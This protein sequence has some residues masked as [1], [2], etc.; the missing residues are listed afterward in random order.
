MKERPILFGPEMVRAILDGSKTMTRRIV[1][2]QP[3]AEAC[4]IT[5]HPSDYSVEV[6]Q[7]KI[8][9]FVEIA[10]DLWPCNRSEAIACPYGVPGDRLWVRETFCNFCNGDVC[11]RAT[12]GNKCGLTNNEHAP[13]KWRPSIHMPR[14]ASR[15]FLEVLEVRVERVQDINGHDV[16][17]EGVDNGKSNPS[18][19]QRWENMQRMA[20]AELWNTIHKAKPEHQWQANPYVWVVKFKRIEP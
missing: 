2:P 20:F 11:Y 16:L 13:Q 19:R 18:C 9:W 6:L 12:N 15:I 10:G 3:P 14:R 4:S 7:D 1:K 8:A 5:Y 17:A